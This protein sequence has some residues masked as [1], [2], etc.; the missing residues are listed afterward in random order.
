M[1][2]TDAMSVGVLELDEDH[3]KLIS[4]INALTVSAGR[5][6]R[7]AATGQCLVRLRRYAEFH[8][9]R[10]E[11]VMAACG[12]PDAEGH[13]EEHQDFINQIQAMSRQFEQDPEHFSE[14]ISGDL[15]DYLTNWLTHHIL[16]ID[17]EY[18]PF[19][20][21]NAKAHEAARA[22]KSAEEWWS[23]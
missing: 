12:Y 14:R 3:Q 1:T 20:E 5:T 7:T 4:A 17:M 16:I 13:Y 10:E 15:R 6:E 11:H 22:F 9:A 19:A 8:F 21:G 23:I 18:R 2:W